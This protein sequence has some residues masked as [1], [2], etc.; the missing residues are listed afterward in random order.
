M[1]DED[2][3]R[4]ARLAAAEADQQHRHETGG[5]VQERLARLKTLGAK[6]TGGTEPEPAADPE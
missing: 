2:Q 5:T 1:T 4:A 3:D 6:I